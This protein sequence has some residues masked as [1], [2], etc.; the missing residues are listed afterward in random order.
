MSFPI[1]DA[2]TRIY[3][4]IRREPPFVPPPAEPDQPGLAP[5]TDVEQG[6]ND[7]ELGIEGP[8]PVLEVGGS[9]DD[10]EHQRDVLLALNTRA[11]LSYGSRLAPG[12]TRIPSDSDVQGVLDGLDTNA[13]GPAGDPDVTHA[14]YQSHIPNVSAQDAYE[15]FVN[16]PN[17]VFNA[18][19]MEIRPPTDRLQDGG[20][21]MLEIG[22]PPP[23]WLPIEIRTDPAN[24]AFTIHTLDG[25]VLRGEQTF[26]FTDDGNGGATLTQDARFQASTELVNDLQHVA[27]IAAA[28]HESWQFAHREVYEQFN[29]DRDYAGMG[30]DFNGDAVREFLIGLAEDPGRTLNVGADVLGEIGNEVLDEVGGWGDSLIDGA[31]SGADW[32]FDTLGIPGGDTVEDLA[33][34]AGDLVESGAD[35]V[36]DGASYVADKAGDAGEAVVD[37]F[38]PG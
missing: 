21:Y 38:T 5:S 15:H 2:G 16:N 34:G 29:G 22:G 28:Q 4:P 9:H 27:P 26:T 3:A 12:D 35:T 33:D 23:A 36:G 24:N 7:L 13:P 37:F 6:P 1:D 14:V 11:A 20:R 31:G 17:E 19:G 30:I 10:Q 8:D 18:G 25:H 32:V